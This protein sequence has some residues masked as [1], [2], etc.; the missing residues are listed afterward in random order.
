M[1]TLFRRRPSRKGDDTKRPVA[2][3]MFMYFLS[4]VAV[5]GVAEERRLFELQPMD[6]NEIQQKGAGGG[7]L[8]TLLS[9]PAVQDIWLINAQPQLVAAS[10]PDLELPMPN[11]KSVRFALEH[12]SDAFDGMQ[13]WQGGILRAPQASTALPSEI[14]VDPFNTISIVRDGDKLV[15]SLRVDGQLYHLEYLSPGQHALVRVDEAKLPPEGEPISSPKGD[16]LGLPL[17]APKSAHSTIRLL[18]VTTDY[19]RERDPAIHARIVQAVEQANAVLR[20]SQVD[21]TYEIAAIYDA[22]YDETTKTDI[23]ILNEAANPQ[24]PFG[25][26]LAKVREV[27]RADVVVVISD[28]G[29]VCG[30]AYR[31]ANKTNA[32]AIVMCYGSLGHEL[33]HTLGADH[34]WAPGN[35]PGSPPYMWGYKLPAGRFRTQMSADC[36]PS[37]PQLGHFSNPRLTYQKEPLGTVEHNDVA[38]LLNERREAV[39]DFYPSPDSSVVVELFEGR[40][41]TGRSCP[42]VLSRNETKTITESGP[43]CADMG[44]RVQSARIIGAHEAVRLCF[45]AA[46]G[47][48]AAACY[49]NIRS[50][51]YSIKVLDSKQDLPEGVF[52]EQLSPPVLGNIRRLEYR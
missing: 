30:R 3:L 32:F 4:N 37:C 28:K 49:S 33:G 9:N 17:G 16:N 31:N 42:I 19:P 52:I 29:N 10:S 34:N 44:A 12:F 41:F 25:K 23:E 22:D 7:Y 48:P 8:A 27:N 38:R 21:I 18:M 5:A 50:G 35:A 11:G 43:D 15:G 24:V 46:V 20:N 36:S 51:D 6:R 14:K 40:N 45:K 47:N 1:M 26:N 39:E 2:W 13:G